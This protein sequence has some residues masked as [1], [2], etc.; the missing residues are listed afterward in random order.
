M[1]WSYIDELKKRDE[2]MARMWAER[3]LPLE[4]RTAVLYWLFG[5][6]TYPEEQ[7]HAA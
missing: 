4:Q 7:L 5:S 6:A 2:V 1:E 3:S